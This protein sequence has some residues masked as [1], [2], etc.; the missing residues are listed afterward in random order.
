MRSLTLTVHAVTGPHVEQNKSSS[1]RPTECPRNGRTC[2]GS[3]ERVEEDGKSD[4]GQRPLLAT[5]AW[6]RP[7]SDRALRCLSEQQSQR[8]GHLARRNE[9]A[10]SQSLLFS[11]LGLFGGVVSPLTSGT[12]TQTRQDAENP[13]KYRD[14]YL[15]LSLQHE[16]MAAWTLPSLGGGGGSWVSSPPITALDGAIDEGRNVAMGRPDCVRTGAGRELCLLQL[17]RRRVRAPLDGV[18]AESHGPVGQTLK[19]NGGGSARRFR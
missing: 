13:S 9:N 11:Q 10:N 6:R 15:A 1:G 17:L 18:D 14:R 12:R 8:H 19:R 16:A 5:A 2:G 4:G 3:T 7:R